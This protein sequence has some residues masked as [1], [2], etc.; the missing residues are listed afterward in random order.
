[1]NID[2]ILLEKVSLREI[3]YRL[4]ARIPINDDFD[5]LGAI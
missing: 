5:L 4:I 2:A 3:G 1:M